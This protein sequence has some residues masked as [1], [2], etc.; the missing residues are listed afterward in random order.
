VTNKTKN[1]KYD[2]IET[3]YRGMDDLLCEIFMGEPIPE[4]YLDHPELAKNMN[5][6]NDIYYFLKAYQT[7]P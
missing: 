5:F 3:L 4:W 7:K 6:V 1:E 2:V